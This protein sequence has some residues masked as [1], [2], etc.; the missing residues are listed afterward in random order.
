MLLLIGEDYMFFEIAA[1]IA[2]TLAFCLGYTA[3]YKDPAAEGALIVQDNGY[4]G[5]YK[6]C[7]EQGVEENNIWTEEEYLCYGYVRSSY[8]DKELEQYTTQYCKPRTYRVVEVVQNLDSEEGATEVKILTH[9]KIKRWFKL[10]P[11]SK[12]TYY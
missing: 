4:E 5:F 11:W 6:W 12:R 2:G 1:P 3:N 10:T 7:E 8:Y 9:G